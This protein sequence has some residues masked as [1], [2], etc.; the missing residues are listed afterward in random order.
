MSRTG[1]R[2]DFFAIQGATGATRLLASDERP[3]TFVAAL[4]FSTADWPV[5]V[6]PLSD[7]GGF[8]W[9]SERDGWRHVYHY[10]YDGL[11]KKQVT[12]GAFPVH[13]VVHVDAARRQIYVL[14]SADTARPYDRHVYRVGLDGTGFTALTA[15]PG[16]H[17]PAFSSSGTFFIDTYSTVSTPPVNHVTLWW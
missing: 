5:Q 11:V 4:D 9:M 12:S 15:A 14:A 7:D 10:G 6:T 13:R 2:L 17:E 1:K 8:L 16:Q 3:A